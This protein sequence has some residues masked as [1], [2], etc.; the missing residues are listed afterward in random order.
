MQ[1]AESSDYERVL[2]VKPEVF[3]YRI[4]PRTTN[5]AYRA[6]EWKLDAPDWTGRMRI[7]STGIKCII[8]LEDKN[9]GE[10]FAACPVESYPS[11]AV[12][13]VSDSAR[14]FVIRIKD[15]QNRTAFIGIGFIDRSDSFDFNVA[16]QD[17]FKLLKKEEELAKNPPVENEKKLDLSFKEGQTIKINIGKKSETSTSAVPRQK[18]AGLGAGGILLPP[19]PSKNPSQAPAKPIANIAPISAAAFVSNTPVAAQTFAPSVASSNKSTAPSNSDLLLDFGSFPS[20]SNTA[21]LSS[22]T[23]ANTASKKDEWADFL[24]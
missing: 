20:S 2:L 18:P 24:N 14:Y 21:T 11:T 1:A 16:L 3:V 23:S 8:K 12:E 7:L 13:S 22:N 6:S 15:E 4:P 19:P 10:L 17:H 9:S 5:R